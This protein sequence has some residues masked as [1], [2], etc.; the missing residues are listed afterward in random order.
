MKLLLFVLLLLVF[1]LVELGLTS[2]ISDGMGPFRRDRFVE[3]TVSSRTGSSRAPFRRGPFRRGPFRR[4]PF[5]RWIG[6]SIKING[7]DRFVE[8]KNLFK[9]YI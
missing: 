2:A 7:K 5:R 8:S 6:S 9:C 4:G 3:S 1:V